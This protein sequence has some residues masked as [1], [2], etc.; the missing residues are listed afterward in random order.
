MVAHAYRAYG[1][2]LA[3]ARE[4]VSINTLPAKSWYEHMAYA[5]NSAPPQPVAAGRDV[6]ID[7]S[8]I[9]DDRFSGSIAFPPGLAPVLTNI[10]GGPYLVDLKGVRPVGRSQ[11]GFTVVE[12]TK[13]G[14]GPVHIVVE[15]ARSLP[16]LLAWWSSA[17]AIVGSVVL[18]AVL[19]LRDR[20]RRQR[21]RSIGP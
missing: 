13:P 15:E 4:L 10:A 19:E 6:S 18:L 12:R 1:T 7:V 2:R 11:I 9:H 14:S 3:H 20:L 16:L 17:A 5:N 21:L 8:M